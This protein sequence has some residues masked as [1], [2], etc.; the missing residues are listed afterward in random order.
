M[1]TEN[2]TEMLNPKPEARPLEDVE[3]ATSSDNLLSDLQ[4]HKTEYDL[5]AEEQGYDLTENIHKFIESINQYSLVDELTAQIYWDHHR[6]SFR[7]LEHY[8]NIGR[9]INAFYKGQVTDKDLLIVSNRTRIKKDTLVKATKF[10]AS[11]TRNH[12]YSLC[13]GYFVL[14]WHQLSQHLSISADEL[15]KVYLESYTPAKFSLNIL[16]P[17]SVDQ[18]KTV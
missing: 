10:A 8:Y 12:L 11:Y 13:R 9:S 5:L 14:S 6:F 2:L 17:K 3:S 1:M 16:K 18:D 7:E 4:N 15:I